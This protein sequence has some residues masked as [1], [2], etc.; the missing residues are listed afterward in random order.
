VIRRIEMHFWIQ[1]N[2]I[3]KTHLLWF[4]PQ[5]NVFFFFFY[6]FLFKCRTINEEYY[7]FLLV[8]LNILKKKLHV[9]FSN[10]ILFLHHNARVTEQLRHKK[11]AYLSVQYHDH[12]PYSPYLAPSNYYLS[13]ALKI[14]TENSPFFVRHGR[15]YSRVV[16]FQRT[17]F[18]IS[19]SGLQK[20]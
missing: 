10:D 9:N 16:L 11:L 2:E 4:L 1:H 18:W 14:T 17:K 12:P 6:F 13:P 19:L 5:K 7:S 8:Q 20:L 3:S 15:H